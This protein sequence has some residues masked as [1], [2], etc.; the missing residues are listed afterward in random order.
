MKKTVFEIFLSS[1]YKDLGPHRGKV[2]DMVE[3]LGEASIGMETFGAKPERPLTTCMLE[4]GR[5]DALVVIVGHRYGWIPSQDEGGDG[6]RSI[7]W[8]E[9]QWALDAGKPVYTYLIDMNAPWTGEKEQDRLVCAVSD[10]ERKEVVRAVQGLQSFRSFLNSNTTHELFTSADDL[11]GKVA[12]SL[13]NWLRDQQSKNVAGTSGGSTGMAAPGDASSPPTWSGSPFPGLRTFTPLDA[14]VFFGRE[15]ETDFLVAKLS[16][17]RCRLLL[18][19]GTSGSGK[20]SLVAAGLIPRLAANAVPGSEDWLLPEVHELGQGRAWL[21]LRFT[22]GEQG[23]NPFQALANKL[24]P[25]LPDGSSAADVAQTLHARPDHLVVFIDRALEGRPSRAEALLFVDQF[26]ELVT[27]VTDADFQ[28]RFVDML[29]VAARSPRLRVIGTVRA[30]FY[31]RCIEAQPV[32]AE[33]L[34]DLGA[35]VPLAGPGARALVDMVE[36]PAR[37]AGLRFDEGLVG[38]LVDQTVSRPGGLALMAFALH[39]LYEARADDGRLTEAAFRTFGRL[40]GVVNTR[41]ETMFER[42]PPQV[43]AHLGAVFRQLVLVDEQG[44]ATRARA[45]LDDI[46]GSSPEAGQLVEAFERARLLV[47]DR[48]ADG[49]IVLEV[50][51]EALLR[52]WTRLKDWIRECADDLRLVR[53]VEAAAREW[54]HQGRAAHYAWPQER[55]APAYASLDRLGLG[56]EELPEPARAFVRP[57]WERLVVELED[58]ATGHQRRAAI[59]DRLHQLG[60]RRPGVGLRADGTPDIVWCGIPGGS[61][62]I[63][64]DPGTKE[65]QTFF[66]AK[67]PVTYN[68]YKA[69]LDDREGY[70]DARHWKKLKREGK[71]GEQYRP[72]GN[73]PAENASWYDAMAFCHWL[74]ERLG[75]EVR[76]PDE[77]EWQQAAT[78]GQPQNSYPWGPKWE[79]GRANTSESRLG[80][81]TAVGMYPQGESAQDAADLAGNVWEWCV[82]KF[83]EKGKGDAVGRVLRGGSWDDTRDF[84]RASSRG[85]FVPDLRSR[86]I[87]LR[88]VCVSPI[89]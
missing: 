18:I 62:E 3:R 61:V 89:R 30:D 35:T 85:V 41:A 73:H 2:H 13:A 8:W 38:E 75:F 68:Q 26:E 52:E 10:V 81:T 82:N 20:S 86:L 5:A 11:A 78:G 39:E 70:Q 1:T 19:V 31:H 72:I 29:A 87:G 79:E 58:P 83:E 44:V 37:R 59:G 21:G 76:L 16:D 63:E 4:V 71:P 47:P 77:R 27:V 64:G 28:R 43:R 66:L 32:L 74:S 24:A 88:V 49:T 56:R 6:D 7:T 84:A 22:P 45:R 51:H 14:P 50:A 53:Q 48:A 57:E 46:V 36:G 67:Y 60:D 12:T 25:M 54:E 80:R 15:R 40:A 23:P 42:L 65:A 55:L 34:R 9:V 33:L 69:F 17:S